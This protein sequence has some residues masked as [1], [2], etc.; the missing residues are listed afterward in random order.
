MPDCQP[1]CAWKVNDACAVAVWCT[2]RVYAQPEPAPL[3]RDYDEFLSESCRQVADQGERAETPPASKWQS[4]DAQDMDNGICVR[5]CPNDSR[6]K[7]EAD[8]ITTFG[9][10]LVR[11]IIMRLLDRQAALTSKEWCWTNDSLQEQVNM[12]T[13]QRDRWHSN[14]T[15]RNAEYDELLDEYDELKAE[16]DRYRDLCGKLLD[17]ADEMRRVRDQF[18]AFTEVD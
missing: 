13:E 11:S 10:G 9:D 2:E 16:R 12:L 14:W 6:E 5:M 7:L 15:E 18:D 17:A 4:N 8:V 3:L 1:D